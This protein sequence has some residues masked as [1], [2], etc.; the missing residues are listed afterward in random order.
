MNEREK[1]E[2]LALDLIIDVGWEWSA[3]ATREPKRSEV[4]AAFPLNN[5]TDDLLYPRVK[6]FAECG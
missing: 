3:P 1:V 2:H 5:R 4:I 6:P